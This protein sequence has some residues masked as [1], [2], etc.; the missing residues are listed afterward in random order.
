MS[1]ESEGIN[2]RQFERISCGKRVPVLIQYN[3]KDKMLESCG[4]VLN[5][6][7]GGMCFETKTALQN[8]QTIFLTFNLAENFKFGVVKSLTVWVKAGGVYSS[9][10][11]KFESPAVQEQLAEALKYFS[12]LQ[13]SG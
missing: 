12:E 10:G 4:T 3:H 9:Y 6:S 1:Q 11:A 8:N 7:L 2:R 5:V 13:K